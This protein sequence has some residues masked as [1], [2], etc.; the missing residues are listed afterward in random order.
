MYRV[1]GVLRYLAGFIL[2]RIG[3]LD[4]LG[5][6]T[7]HEG[8]G[9]FFL[10]TLV[11]LVGTVGVLGCSDEYSGTWKTNEL[12]GG[13]GWSCRPSSDSGGKG[14]SVSSKDRRGRRRA[15]FS[16]DFTLTSS[17]TAFT[18][19]TSSVAL[20]TA[21]IAESLEEGVTLSTETFSAVFLS[22]KAARAYLR[23]SILRR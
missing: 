22:V 15:V 10:L 11:L 23:L 18:I 1:K 4:E 7:A 3:S 16:A 20:L 8:L 14:G 5:V 21:F 12:K 2:T 17:S 6:G 13:L 9:G 19:A